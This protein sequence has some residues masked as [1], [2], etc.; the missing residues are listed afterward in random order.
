[1]K[2]SPTVSFDVFQPRLRQGRLIPYGK[3]V[4]Y[5]TFEPFNQIVL[6]VEMADL[7]ALS[8]GRFNMREIIEKIYQRQGYVHFKS[9]FETVHRL[10]Q[11][12]FFENGH[13]LAPPDPSSLPQLHSLLLDTL[14]WDFCLFKRVSNDFKSPWAFY[15]LS[16]L[17]VVVALLSALIFPQTVEPILLALSEGSFFIGLLKAW[18]ILSVLISFKNILKAVFLIFLTGK[19]YNMGFSIKPWALHFQVGNE[20]QFLI[21]SKTF[22]VLYHLGLVL[23]PLALIT[24]CSYFMSYETLTSSLLLS[25]VYVLWQLNPFSRSQLTQFF[26][27]YFDLEGRLQVSS[28]FS[29]TSILHLLDPYSENSALRAQALF[30][31]IHISWT[32]GGLAFLSWMIVPH[33]SFQQAIAAEAGAEDFVAGSIVLLALFGIWNYLLCQSIRSLYFIFLAKPLQRVISAAQHLKAEAIAAPNKLEVFERLSDLP[34]FNNLTDEFIKRVIESSEMV[35]FEKGHFVVTDG[36]RAEHLFVLFSG[37][38]EISKLSEGGRR[39]L[40]DIFPT[41]IFG[42]SSITDDQFRHADAIATARSAVLRIPSQLVRDLA[43]DNRYIRDLDSFKGAIA[44]NQFFHSAPMFRSLPKEVT[45]TLMNRSKLDYCSS[46]EVVFEQGST[47]DRFYMILRGS[48]EVYINGKNV[49]R[50]R[51]GGF[52][53]EIAVIAAIPR[54]ATIKTAEPTVLLS[55]Q[56]D[57]F[58]EILVQHIELALFIESVGEQRFKEGVRLSQSETKPPRAA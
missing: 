34:L 4:V 12:G 19:I 33:L 18:V 54:T 56:V 53:G 42:E 1:M 37:S 17:T 21:Q 8:G 6:P 2:L 25:L 26:R 45:E 49:K 41:S 22:L 44:V 5:E 55:I 28:F 29:S 24:A 3:K 14:T 46:D 39:W 16:M 11:E 9:I 10:Q 20:S 47:G 58:W 35:T 38:V 48:V 32:A 30:R 31:W 52:F 51:Q 50:I 57:V 15:L 43:Q 36:E 7:V 27:N 40:S 13:E 23:S